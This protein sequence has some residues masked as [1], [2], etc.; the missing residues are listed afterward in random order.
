M[1][2]VYTVRLRSSV[3]WVH[4]RCTTAHP[5]PA[6]STF[7]TKGNERG[8]SLPPPIPPLTA[9]T[10]IRLGFLSE[11]HP[12]TATLDTPPEPNPPN[13]GLKHA[14]VLEPSRCSRGHH[15][16]RLPLF[17]WLSCDLSCCD[18]VRPHSHPSTTTRTNGPTVA[19]MVT[20]PS[21]MYFA[22][23]SKPSASAIPSCAALMASTAFVW[24][25]GA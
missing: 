25:L 21:R 2:K 20:V 22:L 18:L 9:D 10:F 3:G 1:R 14:H 13:S 12:D 8:G 4:G 11:S 24:S 7:R 23:S 6:G 19:S 5:L 15:R 16:A 17:R